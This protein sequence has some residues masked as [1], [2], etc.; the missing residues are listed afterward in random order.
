MLLGMKH[1]YF[2]RVVSILVYPTTFV[3]PGGEWMDDVESGFPASGQSV[4][5]GPV[6]LAW[7]AVLAE[8][9][10]PTSGRN[11]VIHEFAHQLD[12]LDGSVNGTPELS[13]DEQAERRRDVMTSEFQ[14]LVREVRKGHGTFQ[15]DY[16]SGNEA[17]LFAVASERFFTRPAELRHFHQDLYDVLEQFYGVKPIEWFARQIDRKSTRL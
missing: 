7:D 14:H 9:R 3:I 10:D 4:Y 17:E 13:T 8:G 11:V 5:R 1:D 16:A 15:G 6:I 2:C 12:S